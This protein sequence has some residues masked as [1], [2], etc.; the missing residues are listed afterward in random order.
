MVERQTAVTKHKVVI[1][2]GVMV[3]M[4]AIGPKVHKFKPG[5]AG[6]I[7]KGNKNLQH[8]FLKSGS[9]AFGPIFMILW[10]VKDP[11]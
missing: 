1:L 2:N 9:K 3:S 5:R 11:F 4:L 8:A 7:F 10:H 6:W